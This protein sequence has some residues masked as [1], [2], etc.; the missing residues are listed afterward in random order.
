MKYLRSIFM[1]LVLLGPLSLSART[2]SEAPLQV[3]PRHKSGSSAITKKLKQIPPVEPFL[4]AQ[5]KATIHPPS[6]LPH[7]VIDPG[8]GGEDY[9]TYSIKSPKY[10][11]KLLT[12]SSAMMLKRFLNQMGYKTSLTR[13]DDSFISLE[14]RAAIANNLKPTLFVSIHYNSAPSVEAEG[15][16][17]YYYK[18]DDSRRRVTKSKELAHDVLKRVLNATQAKSRGVKHGNFAVIR[19]TEMPA[20]LIEGGFLSHP[21]ERSRIKNPTYLKQLAWGIA[22][23]IDD[24]VQKN[25]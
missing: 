21:D 8:H 11:E 3:K 7:I 16:E 9:G 18:N 23:G 15:V 14:D 22:L 13:K 6:D 10:Q 24:Y 1:M 5:A 25:N 12:L 20:I 4:T 19:E 2:S 17:I